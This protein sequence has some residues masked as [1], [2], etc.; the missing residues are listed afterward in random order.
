MSNKPQK[1]RISYVSGHSDGPEGSMPPSPHSEIA[2][3][4][5][6][7]FDL[8]NGQARGILAQA[9]LVLK[10]QVVWLADELAKRLDLQRLLAALGDIKS[11]EALPDLRGAQASYWAVLAVVQPALGSIA[12]VSHLRGLFVLAAL[13]SR[14]G[15]EHAPTTKAVK[16]LAAVVRSLEKRGS[17]HPNRMDVL[18]SI[19][20]NSLK[21][22]L[23]GTG[24]ALMGAVPT[25]KSPLR[26]LW[27]GAL[28]QWIEACSIGKGPALRDL[29]DQQLHNFTQQKQEDGDEQAQERSPKRRAPMLP[30]VD[31]REI[32]TRSAIVQ[33]PPVDSSRAPEP[34]DEAGPTAEELTSDAVA[35][36]ESK[37]PE[38]IER[39]LSV[40]RI[41]SHN[42]EMSLGHVE[43]LSTSELAPRVTAAEQQFKSALGQDPLNL[44]S[45][46]EAVLD[47][48]ILATGSPISLLCEVV[49]QQTD[50]VEGVARQVVICLRSGH[51]IRPALIAES[52]FMP[53]DPALCELLEPTLSHLSLPLPAT[54]VSCLRELHALEPVDRV[55]L[56]LKES[57]ILKSEEEM[58]KSRFKDDRYREVRRLIASP[59]IPD[60]CS[61]HSL[62]VARARRLLGCILY[63]SEG[64]LS[65][66]MQI[67]GDTFGKSTSSLYYSAPKVGQLQRRYTTAIQMAFG[68][69]DQAQSVEEGRFRSR[70]L[71]KEK[72]AFGGEYPAQSAEAGRIGS[73]GLVRAEVAEAWVR[74]LHLTL[75]QLRMHP[76]KSNLQ[77]LA[78]IHN[79][80]T[81]YV[82]FHWTLITTHRPTNA[83]FEICID[84]LDYEGLLAVLSDKRIDSAHFYRLVALSTLL[85]RQI[86]A[87]LAHLQAI[88]AILGLDH[89]LSQACRQILENQRPLFFFLERESAAVGVVDFQTNVESWKKYWPTDF[90]LLKESLPNWYRHYSCTHWIDRDVPGW[91]ISIQLGHLDA[92]N[93]PFGD[94][95]LLVASRLPEHLEP[96]ADALECSLGLKLRR[97]LGRG[98]YTPP[99]QAL[100]SFEKQKQLAKANVNEAQLKRDKAL[101]A[102]EEAAKE[103]GQALAL[104][105]LNQI[106]PS[107]HVLITKSATKDVK[108]TLHQ[109]NTFNMTAAQSLGHLIDAADEDRAVRMAAHSYL[110]AALRD[111]ATAFNL[112]IAQLSRV[113]IFPPQP[114]SPFFP[115]MMRALAQV[116][117]LRSR[118]SEV[119]K[120]LAQTLDSRVVA[121]VTLILFGRQCDLGLLRAIVNGSF[122]IAFVPSAAQPLATVSFSD[123]R[124]TFGVDALCGLALEKLRKSRSLYSKP[125]DDGALGEAIRTLLFPDQDSSKE[126]YLPA[127]AAWLLDVLCNVEVAN[128]IELSPLARMSN[129][130][131]GSVAADQSLQQ[132][133]LQ[134]EPVA[135]PAELLAKPIKNAKS[136]PQYP[137]KAI[138]PDDYSTEDTIVAQKRSRDAYDKIT[139]AC[140]RHGR[141]GRPTKGKLLKSNSYAKKPDDVKALLRK[142]PLRHTDGVL[143]IEHAL[144]GWALWR[145]D[146][147]SSGGNKIGASSISTYLSAI[148]QRLVD[149]LAGKDL[150]KHDAEDF[151]DDYERIAESCNS[152]DLAADVVIQLLSFHDYLHEQ[153]GFDPASTSEIMRF[154]G[155]KSRSVTPNFSLHDECRRAQ[156]RLSQQ[157]SDGPIHGLMGSEQ[158]R[159]L[160]AT[161][162]ILTLFEIAGGRMS[163]IVLLR[164]GDIAINDR[165]VILFIRPSRY[166]RLKSGAGRRCIV[167]T[168]QFKDESE[169]TALRQWVEGERCRLGRGLT[170]LSLLF[171]VLEN[172][173]LV[174]P[175]GKIRSLISDVFSEST[176]RYIWPHLLRHQW[177][178]ERISTRILKND[179]RAKQ[180]W[181]SA[182]RALHIVMIEVG[183]AELTTTLRCYWHFPWLLMAV[184]SQ[185]QNEVS[186]KILAAVSAQKVSAIDKAMSRMSG[187]AV[188]IRYTDQPSMQRVA[189]LLELAAE[190][191]K[192]RVFS[193]IAAPERYPPDTRGIKFAS[194]VHAFRSASNEQSFCDVAF[195]LGLHE[196]DVAFL[197]DSTRKLASLCHLRLLPTLSRR[198]RRA[199][200][201]ASG[202]QNGLADFEE[203]HEIR[204]PIPR[205]TA[206]KRLTEFCENLCNAD[207]SD[208]GAI[209]QRFPTWYRPSDATRKNRLRDPALIPE[210]QI[211]LNRLEGAGIHQFDV[212][213]KYLVV[214]HDAEEPAA[215]SSTAGGPKNSHFDWLAWEM[216]VAYVYRSVSEKTRKSEL[217][218]TIC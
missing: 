153:Y 18:S 175:I 116:R 215:G 214:R 139:A 164:H 129:A 180:N 46:A 173:R 156:A 208:A 61:E 82:L 37:L 85:G 114:A 184:E 15:R 6:S 179:G 95:S 25:Q 182:Q 147:G 159:F 11:L 127:P 26:S 135:L 155:R 4:L 125:L 169:F 148:G 73:R 137:D 43:V 77:T 123:G 176:G 35:H 170:G 63:D 88:E 150:F 201:P 44:T 111:A 80:F 79:A 142:L 32:R 206:D 154:I 81:S 1:A 213:G 157:I 98:S 13:D 168:N 2:N 165:S 199:K 65:S 112:N 122:E 38:Q 30:S 83:L 119:S 118:F 33:L 211:L 120:D 57:S 204:T 149:L 27:T 161:K 190:G 91:V 174:M 163:E 12:G 166:R 51:L 124:P 189:Y 105:L 202:Q 24:T 99:A 178:Q 197:I 87:Y 198:R 58:K 102:R 110:A 195:V 86:S 143:R 109:A 76:D 7:A 203:K 136:S 72:R 146:G 205:V 60:P 113:H 117:R 21:D 34:P 45:A 103:T 101:L 54:I 71:V 16:E 42:S 210:V 140:N 194:L 90:E 186:R 104:I 56:W 19:D 62:S 23:E 97:G 94:S 132:S 141:V 67:C 48:L 133:L 50:V 131:S 152:A 171:P 187:D 181:W 78:D 52:Q 36:E 84:D 96:G 53:G 216:G 106:N 17:E 188:S 196:K 14:L 209:L 134:G 217:A 107:L 108:A 9:I 66:A 183:H 185:L 121:A 5:E 75:D 144:V 160:R 49:L 28:S 200:K 10:S 74:Q 192:P 8:P 212:D 31:P 158:R 29:Q 70:R 128:L 100:S 55:G 130:E 68:S 138:N 167:L 177:V 93:Y 3:L 218:E 89:P 191:P 162:A 69:K 193:T 115:G 207:D 41:R 151:S 92:V 126:H 145:L 20:S 40:R 172:D 47:M 64:A 59:E 22:Y 39:S